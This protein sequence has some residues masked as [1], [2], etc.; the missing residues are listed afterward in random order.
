MDRFSRCG[1]GRRFDKDA[2][3]DLRCHRHCAHVHLPVLALG[4]RRTV[5]IRRCLKSCGSRL[6]PALG[7][8]AQLHLTLVLGDN[9]RT[10]TYE[11][12]RRKCE[13]EKCRQY[14]EP[15]SRDRTALI[16]TYHPYP[17]ADRRSSSAYMYAPSPCCVPSSRC[18]RD[19]A[20][21][22]RTGRKT[23]SCAHRHPKMLP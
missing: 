18:D 3:L 5:D 6:H 12:S 2:Q 15:D 8:K 14:T 19:A 13:E 10:A 20:R 4:G 16:V 22:R 11:L 23:M 17:P 7:G 9:T 21:V 1:I